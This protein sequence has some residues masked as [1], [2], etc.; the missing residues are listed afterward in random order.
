MGLIDT[1]ILVGL[2]IFVL[3]GF[4]K[5]FIQS[6]GSIIGFFVAIFVAGHY[7]LSAGAYIQNLI[8]PTVAYALPLSRIAG[9]FFVFFIVKLLFGIIVKMVDSGFRVL[10]IIPLAKTANRVGG[11]VVGLVEGVLVLAGAVYLFGIYPL[12]AEIA[13]KLRE[14]RFAPKIV[15]LSGI[16]TPFLPDVTKLTPS[17]FDAGAT[18]TFP[19]PAAVNSALQKGGVP[20]MVPSPAAPKTK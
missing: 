14:S 5:G 1:I 20:V 9:F 18:F 8:G 7:Y 12:S 16:I 2:L 6:I 11:A 3:I 10:S 19:T 17:V 13:L 4:V 15:V